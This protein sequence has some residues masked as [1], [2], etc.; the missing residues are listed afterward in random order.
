MRCGIQYS[1]VANLE[2]TTVQ[3]CVTGLVLLISFVSLV[4]SSVT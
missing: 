2:R 1:G 3:K 4:E